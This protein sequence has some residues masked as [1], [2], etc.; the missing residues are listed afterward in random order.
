MKISEIFSSIQGESSLAGLPFT[1]VRLAGCNLRC[2]YCDTS[3]AWEGGVDLSLENV[4]EEVRKRGI[5]R[6]CVTGGEPLLQ[7][8]TPLLVDRLLDEGYLVTL[9]TNGS[10]PISPIRGECRRV[11]DVKTPGSGEGDSFLMENLKDLTE[12]DEVKFVITGREDY[13]FAREFVETHLSRFR[14]EILYSPAHGIVEPRLLARWLVE[15]KARGR[16]NL[17]IHKYIFPEESR[18][19]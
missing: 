15:E 17:Q 10:L 14:G 8:E 1:F 13:E 4:L 3:Y 16:L 18:G 7:E 19:V 12:R 2:R 5:P 11:V 9:E 6:V